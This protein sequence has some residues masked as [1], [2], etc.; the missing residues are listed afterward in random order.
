LALLLSPGARYAESGAKSGTCD[1]EWQLQVPLGTET[2][3]GVIERKYPSGKRSYGIQWF[4]EQGE[5]QREFNRAWTTKALAKAAFDEIEE[6]KRQGVA[7]RPD[8]TVADC[9]PSGTTTT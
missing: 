5:R 4:D 1:F 7:T 2:A 6:R 8:L 3:M 9:S